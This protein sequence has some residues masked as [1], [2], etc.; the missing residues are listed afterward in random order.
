MELTDQF[1]VP[2]AVED[3]WALLTDVER[4]APCLPGARLDEASDGQFKGAVRVKVGPITVE[5]KGT[6]TFESLDAANHTLVLKAS[7]RESRGQGNASATVTGALVGDGTSTT[8]DLRTDLEITGKVAQFGRGVLADVSSKLLGQFVKN[9]E[10]DLIAA[11]TSAPSHAEEGLAPPSEPTGA[12]ANPD[13]TIAVPTVTATTP[14]PTS[15]VHP[16]EPEPLNLVRL[17]GGSLGKR[18]LPG[19][20]LVALAAIARRIRRIR[21]RRRT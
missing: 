21:R 8:V 1:V 2:L 7:G 3:A 4:I 15:T 20:V 6:A 10:N 17:V 5:Y 11:G 13:D 14:P 19:V 12:P 16:A 9:L 18:L